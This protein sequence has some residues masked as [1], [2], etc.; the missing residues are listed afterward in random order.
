MD[1][2]AGFSKRRRVNVGI[3]KKSNSTCSI[4]S[5][6]SSA[7]THLIV[8]HIQYRSAESNI[9]THERRLEGRGQGREE[10]DD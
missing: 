10:E 1:T 5:M 2:N 4:E 8:N 9:M 3:L 7:P 6:S